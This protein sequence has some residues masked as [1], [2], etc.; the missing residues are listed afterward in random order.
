MQKLSVLTGYTPGS[1]S[2]TFGNIKR[3]LRLIGESLA[4]GPSSSITPKKVGGP[5]RGTTAMLK[6]GNK[7]S[8][9]DEKTTSKRQKKSCDDAHTAENVL[10]KKEELI[11]GAHE[12][13]ESE[14]LQ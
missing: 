9:G 5:R 14:L 12:D 1:A 3:K 10:I 8:A 2:V 7:R 6:P 11:G 4:L 13:S